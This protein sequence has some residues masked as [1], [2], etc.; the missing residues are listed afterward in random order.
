MNIFTIIQIL[1]VVVLWA[2][3]LS[4]GALAFPFVLLLL[5]PFRLFVLNRIFTHEELERVS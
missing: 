4:P 1:C 5:V 3:K 2:V